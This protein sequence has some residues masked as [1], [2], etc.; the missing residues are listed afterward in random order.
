MAFNAKSL[1]IFGFPAVA[2]GRIEPNLILENRQK[3]VTNFILK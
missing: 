2:D 1:G 3:P